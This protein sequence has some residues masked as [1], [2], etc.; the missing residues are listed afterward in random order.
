MTYEI[1]QIDIEIP[2]TRDFIFENWDHLKRRKIPFNRCAYIKTYEGDFKGLT[3]EKI[4]EIFNIDRPSDFK[5]HSLS[6]SDVVVLNNGNSRKAY[7]VDSIGFR[8]I[9]E[10][11]SKE[12]MEVMSA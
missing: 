7:Y 2:G 10:E 11:W 3:L 9:S 6:V 1:W 5:G 12:K 8:N 4:Y